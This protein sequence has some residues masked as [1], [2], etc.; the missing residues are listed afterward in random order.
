MSSTASDEKNIRVAG[1]VNDSVVDGPG[2]RFAVFVQGCP[3]HCPGCHNPETW[4]FDGG[5]WMSADEIMAKIR[6]NPLLRGVTFSGGEPMSQAQAL[7]PLAKLVREA[8]LELAS[9]TGYR[10]EELADVPGASELL[11]YLDTLIDSPFVLAERD[12]TLKFKGSRNQRILDV[13]ASLR[14]GRAV[15]DTGDRWN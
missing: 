9:Y 7:I 4:T 8:G 13:P 15:L 5:T 2:F 10:F 11:T 12:L 3:H 1:L 6:K 14:E